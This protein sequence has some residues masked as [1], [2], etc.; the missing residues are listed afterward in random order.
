MAKLLIVLSLEFA[1]TTCPNFD[2]I[3]S[4][5]NIAYDRRLQLMATG[6]VGA[7]ANER[8]RRNCGALH[9]GDGGL[10]AVRAP[11]QLASAWRIATAPLVFSRA[12]VSWGK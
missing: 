9:V 6:L 12:Q 11:E 3:I 8:I 5:K 1:P 2:E 4:F 7:A 10:Y